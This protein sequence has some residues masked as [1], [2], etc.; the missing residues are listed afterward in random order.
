MEVR[1]GSGARMVLEWKCAM[2]LS[3]LACHL[4][5]TCADVSTK[6]TNLCGW[7]SSEQ[8]D[9]HFFKKLLLVKI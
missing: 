9:R 7:G 2:E 5:A 6:Q 1:Y 8:L 3:S 4:C